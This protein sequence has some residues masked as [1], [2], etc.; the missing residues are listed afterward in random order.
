MRSERGGGW[1]C[2][3]HDT[4]KALGALGLVPRRNPGD[5]GDTFGSK[6]SLGGAQQGQKYQTVSCLWARKFTPLELSTSDLRHRADLFKGFLNMGWRPGRN[7]SHTGHRPGTPKRA[8]DRSCMGD[9]WGPYP[10]H[11]E[12]PYC[13]GGDSIASGPPAFRLAPQVLIMFCYVR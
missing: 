9:E 2:V 4:N 1:V 3:G 11:M 12:P 7:K 10:F 6:S 13:C 5:F 8:L